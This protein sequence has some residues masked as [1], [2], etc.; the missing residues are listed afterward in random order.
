MI[1]PENQ[2]SQFDLVGQCVLG[3]TVA[4]CGVRVLSAEVENLRT[5]FQNPDENGSRC[6]THVCREIISSLKCVSP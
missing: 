5:C 3:V 2:A 4:W 1:R 6:V